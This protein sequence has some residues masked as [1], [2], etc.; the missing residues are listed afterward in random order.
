MT[1]VSVIRRRTP[2]GRE[3]VGLQPATIRNMVLARVLT[4]PAAMPISDSFDYSCLYSHSLC[5]NS[6]QPAI[7][8]GPGLARPCPRLRSANARGIAAPGITI[9]SRFNTTRAI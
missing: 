5:P 2:N 4:V 1:H 3:W 9:A 8:A 6:R 7:R